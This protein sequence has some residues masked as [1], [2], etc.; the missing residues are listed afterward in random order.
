LDPAKGT[1]TLGR[2]QLKE[3]LDGARTDSI[4]DTVTEA[5]K[6]VT[7]EDSTLAGSVVSEAR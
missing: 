4:Q 1:S 3:M 7:G 2:A 5:I 6:A